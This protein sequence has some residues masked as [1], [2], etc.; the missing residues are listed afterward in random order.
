MRI[1]FKYLCAF[2]CSNGFFIR[3][4]ASGVGV[5]VTN[6]RPLFSERN[7]NKKAYKLGFGWRLRFLKS[8]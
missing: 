5:N 2:F 7:G 3:L 4:G 6:M 8:E 1:N